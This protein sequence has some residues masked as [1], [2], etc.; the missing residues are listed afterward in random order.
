MMTHNRFAP[1]AWGVL[2]Y[3]VLVI[4]WGAFVRATGSGA[5]CGAHWPLCDGQV[6][7]R[8]P[9]IE[10]IIEF[11]HRISSGLAMLLVLGL[12]IWAFRA[13][14][15]KH[16]VRLG[17]V[18]SSVVII[19]E[20]LLG[21]GLVLL[22]LVADNDSVARAL[23]IMLHLINTFLLLASL[24]LTAWWASGGAPLQL[25]GQGKKLGLLSIAL[26]LMTILG[27]SGA[28]TALGDTLFP[29][30][31]LVDGIRQDLDSSSH[32]L[33]Q[34]RVIHPI[35]A[36]LSSLYILAI[37]W[38]YSREH[39]DGSAGKFAW[40]LGYLFL[41]QIVLGAINVVLLAP[42]WMQLVHLL[43]ADSLWILLVLLSASVLVQ[44][45]EAQVHVPV[46]AQLHPHQ[47]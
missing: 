30:V 19:L 7:P 42:V 39:S 38:K 5:G 14:P 46:N 23:V 10:Q 2:G 43:V 17:A 29:S 31:S 9:A 37:S 11:S 3:N 21:A 26:V 20:A 24:T 12:L 47:H 28:I 13:Y 8:E 22:G 40:A 4:L 25:R 33:I 6:I 27:A 35:L 16:R 18:L 1:Y 34:L 41:V 44:P 15:K 36:I 32:F 45:R